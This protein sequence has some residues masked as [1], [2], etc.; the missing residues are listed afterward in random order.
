ML[1]LTPSLVVRSLLTRDTSISEGA[2]AGEDGNGCVGVER[3][4]PSG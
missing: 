3:G 1:S 2:S 4:D